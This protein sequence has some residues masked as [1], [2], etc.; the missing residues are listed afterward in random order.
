MDVPF[1]E[2]LFLIQRRS[3]FRGVEYKNK[4]KNY[5][6]MYHEKVF[7][8]PGNEVEV[9]QDMLNAECAYKRYAYKKS[10]VWKQISNKKK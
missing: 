4:F 1:Q 5:N 9:A 7:E 10:L 3:K 6:K 2:W 8:H